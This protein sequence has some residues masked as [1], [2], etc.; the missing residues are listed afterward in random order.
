[1]KDIE[2]IINIIYET[3]A[4]NDYP[5][6]DY[7][8]GSTEGSEPYEEIEPFKGL[9]DWVKID[10]QLLDQHSG[11]LNFF[12]EA[13]LRFFLPAFLIADLNDELLIA[14]P[15][16]IL[17]QGFSDISV[18]H[19]IGERKFIRKTGKNAF[20][21]PLRYGSM[22]FFDY[23]K[24]RLSVFTQD[25]ARAIVLY[26]RYKQSVDELGIDNERIQAAL[27]LFWLYRAEKA[28]SIE[29]IQDYLKEEQEYL[30]ALN[31]SFDDHE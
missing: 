17:T 10:P 11:A 13:G 7:L 20:I 25:E 28:P 29:K 16:F 19:K 9:F 12:S 24:Y 27:D 1:M 4:N 2:L 31:S 21:N 18:E 23:A 15:L 30:I 22:T 26:L 5:G 8:V 14:D 3:F 6:D